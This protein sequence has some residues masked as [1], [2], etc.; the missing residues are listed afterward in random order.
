MEGVKQADSRAQMHACTAGAVAG[1]WVWVSAAVC[2][3]GASRDTTE[4]E[5]REGGESRDRKER[6]REE[7]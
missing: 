7:E 1:F 6:K 4:R 2:A 3:R 5:S